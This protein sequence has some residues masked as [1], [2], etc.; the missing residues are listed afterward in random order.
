MVILFQYPQAQ[1][2]QKK[3]SLFD[4][5]IDIKKYYVKKKFYPST[6]P[7]L[8]LDD[9][10]IEKLIKFNNKKFKLLSST[11]DI[12]TFSKKDSSLITV[13]RFFLFKKI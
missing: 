8:F 6:N 12:G 9:E 1:L 2:T 4:Y 3:T 11:I 5:S 7:V 13:N 10:Q